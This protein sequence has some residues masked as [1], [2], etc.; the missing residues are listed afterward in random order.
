MKKRTNT[1][2]D[3]FVPLSSGYDSGCIVSGLLKMN[4]KFKTYTFKGQE[5]IDILEKRGCLID[6]SIKSKIF[7]FY[8]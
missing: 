4:K 3:I 2:K 8:I 6:I 7:L 1:D 5:N